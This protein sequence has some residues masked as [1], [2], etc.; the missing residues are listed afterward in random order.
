[1]DKNELKIEKEGYS[2]YESFTQVEKEDIL[3]T[4]YENMLNIFR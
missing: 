3:Q 2:I 1:M 4:G